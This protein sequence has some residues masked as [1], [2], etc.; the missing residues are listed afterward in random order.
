MMGIT[1][2]SIQINYLSQ[3][4][5]TK[6]QHERQLTEC[7]VRLIELICTLLA[8]ILDNYIRPCLHVT[9][10]KNGRLLFSIVSMNNGQ[11][12]LITQAVHYSARHH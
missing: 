8:D 3:F 12:G 4:T 5:F 6:I 1:S 11:N 2:F 10:L 7:Q 9:F